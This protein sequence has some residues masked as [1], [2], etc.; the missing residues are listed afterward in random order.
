[1]L[2]ECPEC[3][4]KISDQSDKCIHCGYPLFKKTNYMC[5]INGVEHDLST[6]FELLT[7][8]DFMQGLRNLR[9]KHQLN[10]SDATTLGDII[11]N[12]K[13]IPREYNTSI[14]DEYRN[15]INLVE[16]ANKNIPHCPT[17]GSTNIKPITA[18]ERATSIIGLGIFSKKI[19]KTYKCL[20]C[21]HTW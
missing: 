2:I 17:C 19:N 1:M 14:K 20:I 7:Q 3:H 11:K 8:S 6:E 18:T 9:D 5:Y 10:L 13:Q 4:N 16:D 21:K 12:T 15:Q